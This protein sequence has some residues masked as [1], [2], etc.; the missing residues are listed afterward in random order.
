MKNAKRCITSD[1]SPAD[2]LVGNTKRLRM[3]ESP[4]A[5][6][7]LSSKPLNP[8]C[9]I[10]GIK[11]K[12]DGDDALEIRSECALV[13][14]LCV[15]CDPSMHEQVPVVGSHVPIPEQSLGQVNWEQSSP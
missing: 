4:P 12:L 6:S 8:C 2:D 7:P 1:V 9:R 14:D 13:T 3:A 10:A 5:D 15:F 11:I